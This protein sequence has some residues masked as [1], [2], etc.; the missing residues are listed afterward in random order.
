M[1]GTHLLAITGALS[2][3]LIFAASRVEAQQQR[4]RFSP[5]P[6]PGGNLQGFFP[7]VYVYERE[8]IHVVERTPEPPPSPPAA[9]A[10]APAPPRKPY[11]IGNSYATLP[12]GCM[13]MIDGGV[14]Y[15]HCSGEWYRQVG[16]GSGVQYK[17]VASP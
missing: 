11:A 6:P 13:K 7:G 12:G 10:V 17:A 2:A 15:Y 9:P 16:S 4:P 14:S 5:P 3:L 1:K 8:V